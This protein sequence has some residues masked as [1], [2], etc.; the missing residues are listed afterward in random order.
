TNSPAIADIDSDG[1]LEIF[2]SSY[3]ENLTCLNH[4]GVLEWEYNTLVSAVTPTIADI[5]N[6]GYLDVLFVTN[7]HKIMCLNH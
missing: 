5:E 4:Q 6:D 1:T 3:G 2:F 7:D